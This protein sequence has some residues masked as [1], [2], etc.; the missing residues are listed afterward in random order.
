M[1]DG[2]LADPWLSSQQYGLMGGYQQVQEVG[3]LLHFRGDHKPLY[4]LGPFLA[5][6]APLHNR[7]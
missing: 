4:D 2:S 5:L 1:D 7:K 6:L 3:V